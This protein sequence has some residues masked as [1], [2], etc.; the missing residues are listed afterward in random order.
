MSKLLDSVRVVSN[1]RLSRPSRILQSQAGYSFAH[2]LP[3]VRHPSAH[4][5][6]PKPDLLLLQWL[7][8]RSAMKC[9]FLVGAA[10]SLLVLTSSLITTPSALLAEE[11][12]QS[13]PAVQQ[14]RAL[15]RAFA[16]AA[17]KVTP[18]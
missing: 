10:L 16:E 2:H 12:G 5:V 9:R 14:A 6:L 7:S 13:T 4:V 11:P 3:S 18:A 17:E 1:T 15:S 8:Q